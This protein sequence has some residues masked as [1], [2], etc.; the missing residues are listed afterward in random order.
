MP[1]HRLAVA[2]RER[3]HVH[4][5]LTWPDQ[6]LL[7]LLAGRPAGRASRG[8]AADRHSRHDLALAPGH[9]LPQAGARIAP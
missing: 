3:P 2:Q 7:A 9:R 8:D 4:S 6:A 5:R 1:R